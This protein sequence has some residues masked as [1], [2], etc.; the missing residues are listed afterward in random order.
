VLQK[1]KGELRQSL[2]AFGDVFSNPDLR[3]LE[4]A[5]VATQLGRF[6]YLVAINVYAF[7]AGGAT[8]VGVVTVIRL[9][10]AAIAAPFTAILGDRYTRKWV[11]FGANIGQ[12][13]AVGAAGIVILADGPSWL[14]YALAA[15]SSTVV[16]A[17]RPAQAAV[18]PSLARTPA[19]L[20][21]ANVASSTIESLGLFVGPAVG[22]VL[23]AFSSAGTVFIATG[24]AALVSAILVSGIAARPIESRAR[25]DEGKLKAA[26]A[27]FSTILS[28]RSLRVLEGL[29]TAQTF[30][31]G[32]F[33]VLLVVAALDLL[34][35]GEGGLGGLQAAVGIGGLVGAVVTALL[36]GLG[37]VSGQ[38]VAGIFLWGMPIA[39]IGV[40]PNAG[41]AVALLVLIGIG[42]TVVDVTDLTL[43]QRAVPDEVLARVFGAINMLTIIGLALGSLVA[44][45]MVHTIGIRAALIVTGIALPALTVVLYRDIA[46]LDQGA[47]VDG[48]L[49]DLLRGNHIFSPLPQL[50]LERLAADLVPVQA[51][52]GDVIFRQGDHGD[53]YYV[54]SEG[55][56]EVSV[57]GETARALGAGEGF[58]EIALLRDVPRT[59]TITATSPVALLALERDHFISAVTG[60]AESTERAESMIMSR[61]G[62]MRGAS[63][64]EAV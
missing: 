10:P 50:T 58:G 63:E 39:L 21:A 14:V 32:I 48:R 42:D 51:A 53:R 28:N 44:P 24:C 19:E 25:A 8:A 31:A 64:L 9:V 16:T 61:M 33:L 3:R 43:L 22:G 54:I 46:R 2:S 57:A 12:A 6:A 47:V 27:G 37:R 62:G 26:F 4:L 56:V 36:V 17:F 41:F 18:V 60:H 52:A 29:L 15:I 38:L 34:E 20:T 11:M 35:L 7:T 13:T 59:A 23:L 40:W 45:L 55:Q 5:W 30:V 1:V 49:I